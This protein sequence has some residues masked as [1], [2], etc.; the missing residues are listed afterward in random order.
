MEIADILRAC[1]AKI[2]CG[3]RMK[4]DKRMGVGVICL[5]ASIRCRFATATTNLIQ[6]SA[7]LDELCRALLEEL[8]TGR[9]RA[10]DENG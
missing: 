3:Q 1:D 8:M 2:V 9:V 7:L 4:T 6:E 10:A 5:S